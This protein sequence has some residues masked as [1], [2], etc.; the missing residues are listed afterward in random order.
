MGKRLQPG[1]FS[2]HGLVAEN[3]HIY[4]SWDENFKNYIGR[5]DNKISIMNNVQEDTDPA[6]LILVFSDEDCSNENIRDFYRRVM[7]AQIRACLLSDLHA[8][9]IGLRYQADPENLLMKTTDG[10]FQYLG[11]KRRKNLMHFVKENI[12]KRIH[13]Y[14]KGKQTGINLEGNIL[15]IEWT[16][17]EDKDKFLDWLEDRRTKFD[18]EKPA[19]ESSTLF[20]NLNND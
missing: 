5:K 14:W 15:T 16:N 1:S 9:K 7:I 13:I 18:T 11:K 19:K 8:L 20:D 2:S 10:I 4:Y 3:T 12:L 17:K 6:P